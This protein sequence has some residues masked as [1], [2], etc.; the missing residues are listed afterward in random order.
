[1]SIQEG[2]L[3]DVTWQG[4]STP[5]MNIEDMHETLWELSELG[6]RLEI[7]SVDSHLRV[8]KN[9][10]AL[11]R[12]QKHLEYCFL[13]GPYDWCWIVELV[14][15]HHSLTE[16]S[17][18]HQAPYVSSPCHVMSTWRN[19]LQSIWDEKDRYMED[20]L[21]SLQWDMALFYCESFYVAFSW[22]PTLPFEL[23]HIPDVDAEY[24][25]HA[26]SLTKSAGYYHDVTDWEASY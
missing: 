26:A 24:P 17:W 16:S 8:I 6:F 18:M 11:R 21:T 5:H 7:L 25:E 20:I 23:G 3:V 12:H 15:A 13:R 19:C 14:E 10:S 4:K 9:D 2:V 1:M 22:A